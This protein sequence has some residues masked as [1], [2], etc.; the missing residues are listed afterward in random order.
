VP[1]D[2]VVA[3]CYH[4][5][6]DLNVRDV[7]DTVHAVLTHRAAAQGMSLRAYVVALLTEHVALPT[8]DEWLDEI[9][10]LPAAG[11]EHPAADALAAERDERDTE[12]A[13]A[14]RRR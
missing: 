10:T 11:D 1:T 14:P 12:L 3:V 2:E 4:T 7:P 5:D 9:E 6:M 8:V 13:H